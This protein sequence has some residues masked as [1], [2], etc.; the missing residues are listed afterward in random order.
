MSAP[1]E[2]E[3]CIREATLD[4]RLER[5]GG[6][7]GFLYIKSG[8]ICAQIGY[9]ELENYGGK[10]EFLV[11]KFESFGG[12]PDVAATLIQRTQAKAREMGYET[13][14][15]HCF[16]ESPVLRLLRL[17]RAEYDSFFLRFKI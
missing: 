12:E 5:F 16:K 17:K 1:I 4:E 11:H 7:A 9:M 2:T 10:T 13:V 6:T 8:R 3:G 14:I 15:A